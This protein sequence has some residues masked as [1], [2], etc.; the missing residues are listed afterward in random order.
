MMIVPILSLCCWS[1]TY[2]LLLGQEQSDKVVSKHLFI[3]RSH[4]HCNPT[5]ICRRRPPSS[6][7]S[8]HH[9]TSSSL[10]RTSSGSICV[11]IGIV[12]PSVC[13]TKATFL[14]LLIF[15]FNRESSQLGKWLSWIDSPLNIQFWSICWRRW[16]S[17]HLKSRTKYKK[18]TFFVIIFLPVFTRFDGLNLFTQ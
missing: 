16:N 2:L 13:W 8:K 6:L 10:L 4:H 14:L 5:I 18:H 9:I 17:F 1:Y 7:Q 12:I 11:I 3:R 15:R